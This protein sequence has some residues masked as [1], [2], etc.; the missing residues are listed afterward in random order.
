MERRAAD[1]RT[2]EKHRLEN[3]GRRQNAR[4]PDRNLDVEQR[5]RLFLGRVFVR[6]RPTRELRR[7]AERLALCKVI[8][9]DNSAVNRVRKCAAQ[10]ADLADLLDHRLHVARAAVDR[11]NCKA[12]RT[13]PLECVKVRVHRLA[14]DHLNVENIE[15]ERALR[16]DFRVLLPQRAGGRVARIF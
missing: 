7:A 9:L 13:Q 11:R 14:L 12:E 15:V 8:H 10:I 3:T 6:L 16:R 1:R 4:A 5:R 2:R